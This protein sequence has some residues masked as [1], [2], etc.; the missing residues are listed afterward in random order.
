MGVSLDNLP[1]TVLIRVCEFLDRDHTSSLAAL[2]LTSKSCHV[3]ATVSLFRTIKFE[4]SSLNNITGYVQHCHEMLQRVHGFGRVHRLI[5]DGAWPDEDSDVPNPRDKSPRTKIIAEERGYHT[6][7]FVG[8]KLNA[9]RAD[10][11]TTAATYMTN[12]SWKPLATLLAQLPALMDLVYGFPGQFP[13][14]LLESLHKYLP[15]CRLHIK[16]FRLRS[17]DA[18]SVDP[19][20]VMLATSPCLYSIKVECDIQQDLIYRKTRDFNYEAVQGMVA[21]LAP[22]LKEL[23]IFHSGYS[24]IS[25][26]FPS[27]RL[28]KGFI[29][30]T[31][32]T[33]SQN[34]LGALRCL[35]IDVDNNL[36]GP[37][38]IET[39][40]SLTD[41]SMLEI[42]KL[43]SRITQGTLEYL[44]ASSRFPCMRELVLSLSNSHVGHPQTDEF[45]ALARIFLASL[46]PLES[47][48]LAG[49]LSRLDMGSILEHHGSSLRQLSLSPPAGDKSL[50]GEDITKIGIHCPLLEDL[51]LTVH[52]SKGDATEVGCYKALGSIRKLEYL[53]LNLDASNQALLWRDTMSGFNSLDDNDEYPEAPNDPSFDKFDQQFFKRRYVSWRDP[54]NGHIRDAFINSAVDETLARAIFSTISSSKA[55]GSLPLEKLRIQVSG[56]GRFGNGAVVGDVER[57]VREVGRSWL[58]KRNLRDD[59]RDDLI[60]TEL[61]PRETMNQQVRLG[62]D[63]EQIFRKLW[64]GTKSVAACWRDDWCSFPLQTIDA[65]PS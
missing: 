45:F 27:R 22:N 8:S 42:L 52:R 54:R 12:A 26:S 40:N 14:C 41:F 49:E 63:V 25:D 15:R 29:S 2:S 28:W 39:W 10:I 46:P 11:A 23:Q 36:I 6:R 1:S 19:Y 61:A 58:C 59:R 13:P 16:T 34:V 43:E 18:P 21:G 20:E 50:S 47:L 65:D 5:I 35:E 55:A 48:D 3:A 7:L 62:S 56:G 57:V 30:G 44:A 33:S 51:V 38:L 64:P 60:V 4:V 31:E 53:S 9:F 17:L 24:A 37:Q 32:E